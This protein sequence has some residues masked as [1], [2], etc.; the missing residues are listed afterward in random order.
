[1]ENNSRR[2]FIKNSSIWLG[3]LGASRFKTSGAGVLPVPPPDIAL[4]TQH[5]W[6]DG[7]A[8]NGTD[9][10]KRPKI[11][12]FIPKTQGDSKRAAILVLPGGGYAGLAPHEGAPFA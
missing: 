1:M 6:R 3:V 11:D 4:Q 12:L 9:E 10:T 2:V 5:L 7:S 8:N